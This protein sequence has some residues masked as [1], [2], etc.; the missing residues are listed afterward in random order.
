MAEKAGLTA[1]C[2][3]W[4]LRIDDG[5]RWSLDVG[6]EGKGG[7]VSFLFDKCERRQGGE[8]QSKG[9]GKSFQLFFLRSPRHGSGQSGQAELARFGPVCSDDQIHDYCLV[10][11]TSLLP[12]LLLYVLFFISSS[13]NGSRKHI[14]QKKRNEPS[15]LPS[16]EFFLSSPRHKP[17]SL[18]LTDATRKGYKIL[19]TSY[20]LLYVCS[21][22][23]P[24]ATQSVLAHDEH[25]L[26]LKT[27]KKTRNMPLSTS[28]LHN[29]N[30]R[31]C[32]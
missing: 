28:T 2:C 3:S 21:G 11:Y 26:P 14:N 32:G 9:K 13:S 19:K 16:H 6:G 8:K 12:C 18:H 10:F 22:P 31:Q 30:I 29:G 7:E 17:S 27:S 1:R 4:R 24:R 25:A 20:Q 5:A 15:K 23:G